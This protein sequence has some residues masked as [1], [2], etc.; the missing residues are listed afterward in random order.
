MAREIEHYEAEL[1][2]FQWNTESDTDKQLKACYH[3]PEPKPYLR[4]DEV[5]SK[6]RQHQNPYVDK[7]AEDMAFH[8]A[9]VNAPRTNRFGRGIV[10]G[11]GKGV[12]FKGKDSRL[13]PQVSMERVFNTF[14]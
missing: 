4:H 1:V 7:R 9:K 2:P 12:G 5:W 13:I 10:K 8:Y 3:A 6:I 14:K 11:L